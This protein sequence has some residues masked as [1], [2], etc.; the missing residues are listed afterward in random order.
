MTTRRELDA[1]YREVEN[2]EIPYGDYRKHYLVPFWNERAANG[3]W[4][5]VVSASFKDRHTVEGT[6]SREKA[7]DVLKTR[8]NDF[9]RPFTS[10]L[11]SEKLMRKVVAVLANK[12]IPTHPQRFTN[13]SVGDAAGMVWVAWTKGDGQYQVQQ[14]RTSV[15]VGINEPGIL[16]H[17][18]GD[19]DYPE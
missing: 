6:V 8:S 11:I 9:T 5:E 2:D 14:N 7:V 18:H 12:N 15:T 10:T 4:E 19:F 17:F 13:Y 3:K 1:K 16:N